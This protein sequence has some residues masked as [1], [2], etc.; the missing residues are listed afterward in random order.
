LAF[1]LGA[2]NGSGKQDERCYRDAA[3]RCH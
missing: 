2:S 3:T 1:C